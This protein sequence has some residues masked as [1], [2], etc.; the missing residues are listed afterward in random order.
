MLLSI[1]SL[2]ASTIILIIA[3]KKNKRVNK[4]YHSMTERENKRKEEDRLFNEKIKQSRVTKYFP[5][6]F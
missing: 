5:D 3:I 6:G 4:S 2:I 1:I